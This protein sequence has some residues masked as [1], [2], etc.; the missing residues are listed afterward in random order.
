[1]APPFTVMLPAGLINLM[2]KL[3]PILALQLLMF[4]APAQK[5]S[6]FQIPD[7]TVKSRVWALSGAT[8]LLYGGGLFALD[9]AWYKG[10][11]KSRFHFFNDAGE[12]KQMDKMGHLFSAY[13]MG[14]YS[15]ELWRWTGLPR[16]QQIWI[17]GMSGFAYLSVIEI[18]DGF[19][20]EWGFSWGDMSANIAGSALLIS[21]ELL[22]NE[23]RIQVKFSSYPQ[24]YDDP[25][26][27]DKAN[28]QFGKSYPERTL[29][30]Y[31]AQTYWLSVNLYS[32]AKDSR[33]PKWLNVAVGY[34]ADGMIRAT[35]NTWIDEE[36]V[37]HD[38]SH[39]P[40]IRQFYLSPDVDFTKIPTRKKGVK[41]LFQVLNMIKFPAPALEL[42]SKGQFKLH[43][44]H[45]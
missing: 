6:F 38:Y 7:T 15:R 16:K 27:A 2:K 11:P 33:L 36:G 45:F 28:K 23:Q 18:L 9:A 34:G 21:Q 40:R 44:I 41:V 5:L 20:E 25:V 24:Y 3:L 37:K 30:D 43:A 22:W 8:A 13:M 4:R 19:S 32:F 10:Y 26:L 29:K 1:M 35:D 39:L 12:W 42:T 14:K 17:G 31:N